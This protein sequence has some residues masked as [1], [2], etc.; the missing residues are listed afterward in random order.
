MN[1]D[2][3]LAAA[4]AALAV[5]LPAHLA[6][7]SLV[8]PVTL[9]PDDD[10]ANRLPRDHPRWKNDALTVSQRA[11]AM[12]QKLKPVAIRVVQ[13]WE[14][15]VRSISIGNRTLSVDASGSYRLQ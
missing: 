3:D 12:F 13:F 7:P 5:P 1:A 10:V 11:R 6:S 4:S 14:H 9:D 15:R 8:A 2:R